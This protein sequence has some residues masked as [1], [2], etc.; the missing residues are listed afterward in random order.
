MRT[1]QIYYLSMINKYSS[2]NI[3]ADALNLSPQALSLSMTKLEDELGFQV[4]VRTQFGSFLTMQGKELLSH[5]N[6]FLNAIENMK[7]NRSSK[8]PA[9]QNASI[10]VLA[11]DGAVET[12]LSS[13]ISHLYIDYPK[14]KVQLERLKFSEIIEK[15][16][17]EADLGIIYHLLLDK[18]EI[19]TIEKTLFEFHPFNTERYFCVAHP[20]FPVYNYKFVSLKT[21]SSFTTIFYAPT[22]EIFKTIFKRY[23]AVHKNSIIVDDFAIYK[24]MILNGAGLS[25]YATADKNLVENTEGLKLIPIKE[26]IISSL[27]GLT[28]KQKMTPE[29]QAFLDYMSNYYQNISRNKIDIF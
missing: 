2:I 15:L 10:H 7:N 8:Y 29:N 19:T 22:I 24:Q 13:A 14:C 3:A 27:G 25:M 11:T 9:L 12:T 26:K 4:L 5:G 17:T 18:T 6:T 28:R 21:M 23:P 20:R 1:E 16:K